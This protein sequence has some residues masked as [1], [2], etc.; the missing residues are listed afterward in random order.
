MNCSIYEMYEIESCLWDVSCSAGNSAL[1][2]WPVKCNFLASVVNPVSNDYVDVAGVYLCQFSDLLQISTI[3]PGFTGNIIIFKV[4]KVQQQLELLFSN[5]T[6]VLLS[7][8]N[9][10]SFV[11]QGK[12]K[13]VHDS[14]SK[15]MD[16]TPK[17]D[18]HFSKNSTRVTSLQSYKA[19][20]Y[21][22][23]KSFK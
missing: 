22:Q 15:S 11:L 3:E 1:L 8:R 10:R 18:S 20:E 12:V 13:S 14:M 16:P 9:V 19:F 23:V 5:E 21:T 17:F 2:S 4:I 7:L 6:L